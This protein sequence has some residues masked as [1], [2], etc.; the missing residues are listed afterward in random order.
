[1]CVYIYIYI[2]L[3]IYIYMVQVVTLVVSIEGVRSG[4][5]LPSTGS[6][7]ESLRGP[8]QSHM[9]HRGSSLN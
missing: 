7:T 3:Y 9:N 2:Y 1:M 5:P 4:L 8:S 6:K